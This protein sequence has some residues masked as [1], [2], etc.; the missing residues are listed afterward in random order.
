ME[1]FA[2]ITTAVQ[3]ALM[4]RAAA[5]LRH[6]AICAEVTMGVKQDAQLTASVQMEVQLLATA[7]ASHLH[8]A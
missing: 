5:H 6:K 1:M 2:G 3:Y 8:P 4:A 7:A